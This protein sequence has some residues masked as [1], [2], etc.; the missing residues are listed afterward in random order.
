M[1]NDQPVLYE[2]R[3]QTAWI[4][5][6][7]PDDMNAIGKEL[8]AAL[9]DALVQA[10]SDEDVRVVVLSGKGKAFC[11]GANLKELMEDLEVK[12]PQTPGL[13]DSSEELFG[14]LE[15][16]SKPIIAALNGKLTR[17]FTGYNLSVLLAL[18]RAI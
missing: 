7:R 15:R 18:V 11:A 8:L 16:Y 1:M 17:A 4:Y 14:K 5:L 2:K 9:K 6:N 10:E 12:H 13:L 3:Q